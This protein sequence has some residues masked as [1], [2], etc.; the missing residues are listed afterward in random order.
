[1]SILMMMKKTKEVTKLGK[2]NKQRKINTLIKKMGS[3]L[4]GI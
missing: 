1:M 4:K 3:D 2:A